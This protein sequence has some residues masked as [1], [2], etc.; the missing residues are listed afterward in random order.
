MSGKPPPLSDEAKASLKSFARSSSTLD[1]SAIALAVA[2]RSSSMTSLAPSE[3]PTTSSS[4]E[5]SGDARIEEKDRVIVLLN[6]TA[7]AFQIEVGALTQEVA[8]LTSQLDQRDLTI[9]GLERELR[10]NAS[11]TSD[12]VKASSA[13]RA[14]LLLQQSIVDELKAQLATSEVD[15]ESLRTALEAKDAA[16]AQHLAAVAEAKTQHTSLQTEIDRLHVLLRRYEKAQAD[17][18]AQKPLFADACLSARDFSENQLISLRDDAI[19]AKAKELALVTAANDALRAQLDAVE[20]EVDQL[21]TTLSAKEME[22]YR[23]TRKIEKLERHVASL[24]ANAKQAQGR[25]FAIELSTKQNTQLLQCLQAQEAKTEALQAE[26][27]A[28]TLD[29]QHAKE[30]SSSLKTASVAVEIE[31]QLK[32]KS[33]ERQSSSLASTLEK[34]QKEREKVR[35]ELTELRHATR[36]EV[37]SI[38]EE[39]VLRRNKQYELTLKLQERESEVHEL[40]HAVETTRE[41]LDATSARMLH[42]ERL[43][44]DAQRW[45]ED[46]K[47]VLDRVQTAYDALQLKHT[48][49]TTELAQHQSALEAQVRELQSYIEKLHKDAQDAVAAKKAHAHE[50]E[51]ATAE[52]HQLLDRIHRLVAET[53]RETKLRVST[54]MDYKV[55]QEQLNRMQHESSTVLQS[56]HRDHMTLVEKVQHLETQ[57]EQLRSEC[58]LEQKGKS[59]LLYLAY[60][61]PSSSGINLSDCWVSDA[62][63]PYIA[64]YASRTAT[65]KGTAIGTIDLR[66]NRV[67]DAGVPS[68]VALLKAQGIAKVLL[69]DNYISPQGLRSLA[70]GIQDLGYS[71]VV[72]DRGLIEGSLPEASTTLLVDVSNNT[73]DAGA[74][75]H[76]PQVPGLPTMSKVKSKKSSKPT[77]RDPLENIYGVDLVQSLMER[78]KESSKGSSSPRHLSPRASSLPKL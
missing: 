1:S 39:L 37:E 4:S 72:S 18:E 5:G 41:T 54:E 69:Q 76:H 73:K 49:D 61:A 56:C 78:R 3:V 71:V 67:T 59:K 75:V 24:E 55:L 20:A 34:V 36:L 35:Q 45:K 47:G 21:Q 28:L 57:L 44:N 15:F 32:S 46:T 16:C 53:N 48:A 31:Y 65:E 77:I 43:Y 11:S 40:R 66:G 30:A 25:E 2:Q 74:L 14:Q 62:E 12:Q 9:Q 22:F 42:V 70:A 17:R 52:K 7:K 19:S 8:R 6:E 68:L 13:F 33:V 26:V 29:L 10:D 50:L 64:A 60:V 38:Q 51:S 63:L 58:L 23:S 27:A